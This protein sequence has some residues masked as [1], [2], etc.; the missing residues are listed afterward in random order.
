MAE[1]HAITARNYVKIAVLLAVVTGVEVAL[2]Y[3]N[4]SL[5]L[6]GWDAPLLIILSM[7]KFV[8]VIGWFMHLRYE[9]RLLSRFFA[10]GFILALSLYGIVVGSFLVGI[11]TR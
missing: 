8:V 3:L 1:V 10:G 11:V 9:K 4:E 6:N 7:L 5:D 2:F